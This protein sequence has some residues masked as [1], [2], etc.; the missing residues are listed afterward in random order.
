LLLQVK[1]KY[2]FISNFTH[3]DI[4]AAKDSTT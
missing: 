3:V 4:F 2:V 1:T